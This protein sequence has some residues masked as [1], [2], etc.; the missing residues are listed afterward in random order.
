MLLPMAGRVLLKWVV[1]SWSGC[2]GVCR[3]DEG[4]CIECCV[5]ELAGGREKDCPG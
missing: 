5:K 1:N 3:D 2:G 4:E